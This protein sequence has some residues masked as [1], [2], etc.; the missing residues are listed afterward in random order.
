MPIDT[1]SDTRSPTHSSQPD[2]VDD[3][4]YTPVNNQPTIKL[5]SPPPFFMIVKQWQK[6][7]QEVSFNF[8]EG[9]IT[10]RLTNG[11]IRLIFD[12]ITTFRHIQRILVAEKA[13]IHTHAP[14]EKRSLKV[15]LR[16]VPSSF[17][18]Q[19]VKDELAEQGFIVTHVRQF[20]K[21]SRKFP[22]FMVVLPNSPASKEIF[23]LHVLFYISIKVVAYKTSGPS[24]C[25]RCQTPD[26]PPKCYNCGGV[27]TANHRKCPTFVQAIENKMRSPTDLSPS[28]IPVRQNTETVPGTLSYSQVTAPKQPHQREENP[29]ESDKNALIKILQD[30]IGQITNSN[31]FKISV[32]SAISALF[33]LIN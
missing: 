2:S 13:Q 20:V 31:D 8:P 12:S 29:E 18:K 22:M 6:T 3:V 30:G 27:H 7:V 23:S 1:R 32:M 33:V 26:M 19:T 11:K 17:A 28:I 10:A 25:F 15:H 24:Q 5:R 21:Q 4:Q 14:Q 9:A 16:G